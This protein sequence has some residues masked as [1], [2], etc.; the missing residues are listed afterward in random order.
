MMRIMLIEHLALKTIYN[1]NQVLLF[2]IIELC[3]VT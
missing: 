2:I 1:K 3:C